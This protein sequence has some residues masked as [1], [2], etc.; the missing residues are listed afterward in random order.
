MDRNQNSILRGIFF[1]TLHTLG[2]LEAKMVQVRILVSKS[3][4]QGNQPKA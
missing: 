1:Y 4:V 2:F 3:L